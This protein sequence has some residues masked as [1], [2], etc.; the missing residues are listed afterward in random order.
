MTRLLF[1]SLALCATLAAQ[2]PQAAITGSV[3]D[4]QGA[5]VPAATVVVRHADTQL[6]T[7]VATN[8]SGLFT[9]RALPIGRYTLTVEHPGFKRYVRAGLV[10]TTGQ[11]LELNVQLDIG[12]ATET[13]NVNARASTLDT[14]TF[15]PS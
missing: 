6:T 13:V 8:G 15:R 11:N 12:Q 5:V 9:A 14:R 2:T 4:T 3:T 7:S 10:L 1:L